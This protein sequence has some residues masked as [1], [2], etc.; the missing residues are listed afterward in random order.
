MFFFEPLLTLRVRENSLI[1]ERGDRVLTH[2]GEPLQA[3]KR[4]LE[5]F[6]KA[7][8]KANEVPAFAC[9]AVLY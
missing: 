2:E 9:G 5:G 8:D 7:K 3:L 4:R 1:E 6:V